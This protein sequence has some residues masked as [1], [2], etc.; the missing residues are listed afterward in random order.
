MLGLSNGLNTTNLNIL[1]WNDDRWGLPLSF[2]LSCEAQVLLSN[3]SA[4]VSMC[5]TLFGLWILSR[6]HSID[7]ICC[8]SLV[9]YPWMS[10]FTWALIQFL[11]AP[12]F[13][14]FWMGTVRSNLVW[15]KIHLIV[16][17]GLVLLNTIIKTKPNQSSLAGLS[18]FQHINKNVIHL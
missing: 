3:S 5:V 14:T 10:I 6:H 2:L 12:S 17:F 4:Q 11:G 15:H 16:R 8:Q 7:Q 1:I 13:R 18:L 9:L